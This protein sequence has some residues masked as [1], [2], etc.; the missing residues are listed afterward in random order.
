[1]VV[2]LDCKR[3][4]RAVLIARAKGENWLTLFYVYGPPG[5]GKSNLVKLTEPML[6]DTSLV[7]IVTTDHNQFSKQQRV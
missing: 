4:L 5:S 1:V 6:N 3:F 7:Q 2:V